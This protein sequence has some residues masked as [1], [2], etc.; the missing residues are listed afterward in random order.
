MSRKKHESSENNPV[1]F[2]TI[3]FGLMGTGAVWMV[4]FYISNGALPLPAVGTWNILI[5]FGIIMAG[6]AMMSRWK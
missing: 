1:W 4:L 3:M 5:A 2:P 6:F